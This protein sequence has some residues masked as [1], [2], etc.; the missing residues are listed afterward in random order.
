MP[1]PL[2]PWV[3]QLPPCHDTATILATLH[4]DADPGLTLEFSRAIS[5]RR[6][7]YVWSGRT[8]RDG[9]LLLTMTSLSPPGVTG[10]YQARARTPDGQVAGRWH[11]IP[12]NPHRRHVLYFTMSGTVRLDTV[13]SLAAAKPAAAP[14]GPAASGLDPSFPNPFNAGTSIPYR[15]T[16]AGPVRLEVYNL[17][18]QVVRTLVDQVQASGWHRVHW[19]AR[20]ESGRALAAGVYLAAL[21]YPGGRQTRRLVHLE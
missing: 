8:D 2:A 12:L 17:L 3:D 9:S 7:D 14:A 15:L 20:D 18:G 21:R 11:S 16:E 4:G 5:G 6:P 13:E 1:R 19:D 10:L